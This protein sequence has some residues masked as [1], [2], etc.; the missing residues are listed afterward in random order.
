MFCCF[1]RNAAGW[2][3]G[4][5][6]LSV[7]SLVAQ[8]MLSYLVLSGLVGLAV[9]YYYDDPGNVKLNNILAHGLEVLGLLL[10]ATSTTLPEFSVAM[11]V[12]LL[13]ARLFM[14]YGFPR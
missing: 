7:V 14:A 3:S 2:C 1:R 5:G 8:W 11:A 12:A 6:S 13:G 10:V 4:K 9:T